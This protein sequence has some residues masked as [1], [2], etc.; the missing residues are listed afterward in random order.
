M[1]PPKLVGEIKTLLGVFR[2]VIAGDVVVAAGFAA[3]D[4]GDDALL[5]APLAEG[6]ESVIPGAPRAVGGALTGYAWR[7]RV[8][9]RP[10]RART[11]GA[12]RVIGDPA[13]RRG[14]VVWRGG[15][16]CCGAIGMMVAMRAVGASKLNRCWL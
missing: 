14:G 5:G 1:Q 11:T 9:A 4:L 10:V 6:A 3:R 7:D 16:R 13:G 12:C 15:A 8:K 2:V